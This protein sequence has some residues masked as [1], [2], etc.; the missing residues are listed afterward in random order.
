MSTSRDRIATRCADPIGID[1]PQLSTG[2]D[3]NM[4]GDSHGHGERKS[5]A[6]SSIPD[7]CTGVE[8]DKSLFLLK[9]RELLNTVKPSEKRMA[10]IDGKLRELKILIERTPNRT[11]LPVCPTKH[12]FTCF[13]GI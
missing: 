13:R 10:K 1:F 5:R 7:I 6:T 11:R 8:N 3:V 12:H 2:E 9:I 4:V